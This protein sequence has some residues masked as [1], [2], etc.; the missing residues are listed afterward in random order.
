MNNKN[1]NNINKN[2]FIPLI[3]VSWIKLNNKGLVV[4]S[5]IKLNN[6]AAIYIY[7]FINDK[8][9]IYVGSTCNLLE[10]I[11]QHRYSVNNGNKNC[12]KFYNFVRKHGWDNFRLGI[13]EFINVSEF[14]GKDNFKKVVL[15]REQY[16]LDM[17]N[18]NLNVNKTAG[19]TLYTRV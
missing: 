6:K 11:K 15:N 9:K 5:S 10:R 16:Y 2:S 1:N 17:L 14:K 7:Q 12:P 8:S 4:N 3:K 18:P 19:S 13:L